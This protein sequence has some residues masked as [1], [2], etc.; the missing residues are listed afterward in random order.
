[1]IF[2]SLF[3]Q[4]SI[5]GAAMNGL[6]VRNDVIQNNISNVDTVNFKKSEAYFEE[7]LQK[8]I[9][10]GER[11]GKL[12]LSDVKTSIKKVHENYS[13]RLDGNNVDIDL[14]MADLYQN[15]MK[16]EALASGV[17]NYYKRI[18]SVLQAR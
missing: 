17:I 11:T 3:N 2:D 6:S 8:A 7:T 4:T 14:E 1:M 10:R 16:Y 15:G 18:N 12:D 13:Y 5:I 9:D